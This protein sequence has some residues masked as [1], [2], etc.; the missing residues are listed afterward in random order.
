MSERLSRIP[1]RIRQDWRIIFLLKNWREVLRLKLRGGTPVEVLKFRDGTVLQSP[2]EGELNFLF[3][4]VWMDE[5]YCPPGYEI[6]KNDIVVDIGANVG[7]FAA[8]AATRDTTVKVLAFEPFPENVEWLRKNMSESNLSNVKI[9]QQAVGGTSEDRTLNISDSGIKHTL[10]GTNY[11][12]NKVS[13]SNG[14]NIHVECVSFNE[15]LEDVPKCDLLKIDCEGSEYEIFYSSSPETLKK[16]RKIVGEFHPRDEHKRNGRALCDYLKSNGFDITH[17][18]ILE[19]GE[20][21]FCA[22]KT[23]GRR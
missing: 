11:E 22:S 15:A 23:N 12:K 14:Q 9:Y 5:I 16:V 10:D 3:H 17:F 2:P 7:V 18:S 13:S 8:Y 21:I 20:G 4:E 1:K 19:N 6:K